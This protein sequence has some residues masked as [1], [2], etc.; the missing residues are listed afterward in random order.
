MLPAA[1][2]SPAWTP[3]PSHFVAALL[4]DW[5]VAAPDRCPPRP[6]FACVTER[7]ATVNAALSAHDEA[8]LGRPLL[9]GICASGSEGVLYVMSLLPATADSPA[10][11]E[12]AAAALAEAVLGQRVPVLGTPA[13]GSALH[14]SAVTARLAS[15]ATARRQLYAFSLEGSGAAQGDAAAAGIFPSARSLGD[16]SSGEG[17]LSHHHHHD[18]GTAAHP[19]LRHLSM[20]LLGL[21]SPAAE[22]AVARVR[23]TIELAAASPAEVAGSAPQAGVARRGATAYSALP[24][25]SP[26]QLPAAAISVSGGSLGRS[27]SASSGSDARND[28]TTLAATA[29][30]DAEALSAA[31]A[32][33]LEAAA[34]GTHNFT[35]GGS[36]ASATADEAADS[37]DASDHYVPMPSTDGDGD[38]YAVGDTSSGD[39]VSAV[40]RQAATEVWLPRHGDR[41][42]SAAVAS[43]SDAKPGW[44]GLLRAQPWS[45]E[46]AAHVFSLGRPLSL[47]VWRSTSEAASTDVTMAITGPGT[48][49]TV[50]GAEV[51]ATAPFGY[52]SQPFHVHTVVGPPAAAQAVAVAIARHESRSASSGVT[53]GNASSGG[54]SIASPAPASS[55]TASAVAM[56]SA[57]SITVLE[58]C[59]PSLFERAAAAAAGGT[60]A[61]PTPGHVASASGGTEG[62]PGRDAP[63]RA[64]ATTSGLEDE[65][66]AVREYRRAVA[67]L[68]RGARLTERAEAAGV[69]LRPATIDDCPAI[70]A[71][72]LQI[73]LLVQRGGL[74]AAGGT[75]TGT[76]KAG[77]RRSSNGGGVASVGGPNDAS[78]STPPPLP[79]ITAAQLAAV[80]QALDAEDA[81]NGEKPHKRPTSLLQAEWAARR[82]R[83]LRADAAAG[84]AYVLTAPESWL[85]GKGLL[86][87]AAAAALQRKQA[88][89]VSI[90]ALPPPAVG[91]GTPPD[92]EHS[93]AQAAEAER[94]NGSATVAAAKTGSESTATATSVPQAAAGRRASATALL[95]SPGEEASLADRLAARL[96]MRAEQDAR[97]RASGDVT[98]SSGDREDTL[99]S[100]GGSSATWSRRSSISTG[101]LAAASLEGDGALR[102]ADS[103]LSG[104]ARLAPLPLH[105]VSPHGSP[106]LHAT[107]PA[108][109]QVATE[110]QVPIALAV[111]QGR[112]P[113]GARVAELHVAAHARGRGVTQLLVAMI[114]KKLLAQEGLPSISILSTTSDPITVRIAEKA[115][116]VERGSLSACSILRSGHHGRL[117]KQEGQD[118]IKRKASCTMQ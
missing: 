65:P 81:A 49:A 97:A 59:H 84:R 62:G 10:Q 1:A 60:L 23:A 108:E 33:D 72:I 71:N 75:G 55:A 92:A 89:R 5:A 9:C 36:R 61:A 113:Y 20:P 115:G 41:E 79:S 78:T 11:L 26:A 105:L 86:P 16:G 45:H 3:G 82:V 53:A 37:G 74:S 102:I 14:G 17:P 68:E 85:A 51:A 35:A 2:A 4:Y 91:A 110:L 54:A 30:R 69:H 117:G 52:L 109:D 28:G 99:S 32:Q 112:S 107:L 100:E 87:V 93:D 44:H 18:D 95:Y 98:V 106:V 21:P 77:S 88:R 38:G 43:S 56:P 22:E 6:L 8:G 46:A 96:Q 27:R 118:F 31:M 103:A 70:A 40:L 39:G 34:M 73:G 47:P 94:S 64:A 66:M 7:E 116:F 58:C 67:A 13:T 80:Q 114:S 19:G 50:G 101:M 111:V 63:T 12:A 83:Q 76:S 104:K 48:T 24:S 29:R 25:G 90:V 15:P 57:A 42:V